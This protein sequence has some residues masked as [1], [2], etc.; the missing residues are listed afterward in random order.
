MALRK[1]DP[2]RGGYKREICNLN[3]LDFWS[4]PL[5]QMFFE[6]FKFCPSLC[7]LSMSIVE[8]FM[9]KKVIFKCFN[10]FEKFFEFDIHCKLSSSSE[11]E[12]FWYYWLQM[13][14]YISNV[15]SS[16]QMVYAEYFLLRFRFHLVLYVNFITLN[17]LLRNSIWFGLECIEKIF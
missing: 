11:S 12:V 14:I 8:I 4:Y 3:S 9:L 15:Y 6:A 1:W 7:K 17:H 16:M 2:L 5:F 10:F 13:K